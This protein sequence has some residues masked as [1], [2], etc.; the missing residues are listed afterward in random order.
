MS[1]QYNARP[2][3]PEVLVDG[4]RWALA[5]RR[6]TFS[7]LVRGETARPTWRG[8]GGK[9]KRRKLTATG[10]STRAASRKKTLVKKGR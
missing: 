5:R 7:D 6:E 8:I 10:K 3:A 9:A 4:D 1:S 2:R